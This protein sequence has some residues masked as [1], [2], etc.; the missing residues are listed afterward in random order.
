MIK[1]MK[2]IVADTTDAGRRMAIYEF[3]VFQHTNMISPHGPLSTMA[4]EYIS[5]RSALKSISFGN[6]IRDFAMELYKF[7]AQQFFDTEK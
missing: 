6:V 1:D 3:D 7:Y 2:D 5:Q 4:C